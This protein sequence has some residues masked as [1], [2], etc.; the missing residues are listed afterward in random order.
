MGAQLR[1]YRRR[2]R[3]VNATKKITKAMELIAASRIVKA[4]QRVAE[5]TPY[6]EAITR[7]VTAVTSFSDVDHPLTRSKPATETDGAQQAIEQ[8]RSAREVTGRFEQFHRDRQDHDL[9]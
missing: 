8:E 7:A 4:Q 9:R 3:S 6:A 2:I 5:S 1:V